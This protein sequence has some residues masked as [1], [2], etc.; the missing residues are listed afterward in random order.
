LFWARESERERF[1]Q[2]RHQL[3]PSERSAV[4]ELDFHVQ[5]GGLTRQ[6]GTAARGAFETRKLRVADFLQIKKRGVAQL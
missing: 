6:N 3:R 5:R 4:D 2:F 1:N